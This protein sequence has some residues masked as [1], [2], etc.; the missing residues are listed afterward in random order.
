MRTYS[1][2]FWNLLM[3]LFT[4]ALLYFGW[5]GYVL[6]KKVTELENRPSITVGVDRELEETVDKMENN[7]KAIA[8][9]EFEL[10]GNPLETTRVVIARALLLD[11][12]SFLAS[13]ENRPRLSCTIDGIKPRAIVRLRNKNHV[14][15][16]GDSFEGYKVTEIVDNQIKLR[17]NGRSETLRVE[18]A[19]KDLAKKLA[20]GELDWN[21]E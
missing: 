21:I 4:L 18:A 9:T 3:L 5:E 13:L 16:V 19:G 8:D 15:G 11:D 10:A 17:R 7:L 6:Q 1:Q 14:V 12:A 20:E 2:L